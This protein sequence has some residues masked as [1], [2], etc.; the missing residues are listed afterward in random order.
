MQTFTWILLGIDGVVIVTVLFFV[1]FCRYHLYSFLALQQFIDDADI[2]VVEGWLEERNFRAVI[3][4]F[5]QGS[6]QYLV[7]VGGPLRVGSCVSDHK[8]IA[9]LA[10]TTL[11]TM[12]F[13][14]EKLIALPSPFTPQNR[15][16][17]TA[18]TF[19][20]W[21]LAN[22]L[23]IQGVNIFSNH[24]HARRT[25]F[26]YR[27]Y[28]SPDIRV[29]VMTSEPGDFDPNAWWTNSYGAKVVIPEFIA[30]CHARYTTL[31]ADNKT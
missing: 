26:F 14:A 13:D 3:A 11:V 20:D 21:L 15:T 28:L 2:L 30:Y 25:H 7:T 18:I 16:A 1:L 29:G 31:V 6:Y 9:E 17:T 24:V 12:G 10:A 27:R 5:E 19:R 22:E 4:E 8:T 23:H